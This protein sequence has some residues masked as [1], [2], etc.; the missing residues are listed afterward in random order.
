MHLCGAEPGLEPAGLERLI[1]LFAT[2]GV[3]RFFVWLSPGPDMDVARR[4][5]E[6]RGLCR[7]RRTGYPTLYRESGGP[8]MFASD[9][10]IRE[11]T[12]DD[13]APVLLRRE[14]PKLRTE[15]P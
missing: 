1:D 11:V 2:A 8:G 10:Q 3:K 9:L 13:V 12:R 15:P 6:E 5:L 7:I 4:W 14:Q